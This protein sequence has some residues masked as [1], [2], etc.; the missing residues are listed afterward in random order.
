[1]ATDDAGFPP[2]DRLWEAFVAELSRGLR[3]GAARNH[4]TPR[5]TD[6]S[7]PEKEN[8]GGA[9]RGTAARG[10]GS[11]DPGRTAQEETV[12]VRPV[13]DGTA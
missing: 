4:G 5:N 6:R 3:A 12:A 1:M 7:A 2:T 13:P 10:R 11:H 9:C 8:E